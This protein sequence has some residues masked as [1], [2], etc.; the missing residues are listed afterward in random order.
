MIGNFVEPARNCQDEDGASF[1]ECRNDLLIFHVANYLEIGDA[2]A[3][4]LAALYNVFEV[5]R[6]YVTKVDDGDESLTSLAVYFR[7]WHMFSEYM[8]NIPC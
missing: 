1:V 8:D 2:I 3:I 5:R 4:P 6:V 7:N